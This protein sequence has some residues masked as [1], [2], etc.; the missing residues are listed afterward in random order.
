MNPD[1]ERHDGGILGAFRRIEHNDDVT[2]RDRARS[3]DLATQ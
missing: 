1:R 2:L 3:E